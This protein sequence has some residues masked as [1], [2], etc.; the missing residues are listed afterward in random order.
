MFGSVS[1]GKDHVLFSDGLVFTLF[2]ISLIPVWCWHAVPLWQ[3]VGGNTRV[4][5]AALWWQQLLSCGTAPCSVGSKSGD[6]KEVVVAP[7]PQMLCQ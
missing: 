2:S 7:R 4:S 5:P 3:R 1:R 6:G